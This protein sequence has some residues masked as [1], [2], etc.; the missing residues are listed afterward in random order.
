MKA[1]ALSALLALLISA[2]SMAASPAPAQPKQPAKPPSSL[3]GKYPLGNEKLKPLSVPTPRTTTGSRS[4]AP[5]RT[6]TQTSQTPPRSE[7]GGGGGASIPLWAVLLGALALSCVLG[8]AGES[9]VGRARRLVRPPKP[10]ELAQ[11][12]PTEPADEY[13]PPPEPEPLTVKPVRAQRDGSL[14]ASVEQLR[15]AAA[16]LGYDDPKLQAVVEAVTV[17]GE[18]RPLS[19]ATVLASWEEPTATVKRARSEVSRSQSEGGMTMGG[20]SA[21]LGNRVA[22]V[23]HA[24]EEVAARIREEAREEAAAIRRDAEDAATARV[25]H[26][27][28]EAEL[29]HAKAEEVLAEAEAQA[30]ARNEA[31]EETAARIEAEAIKHQEDLNA[32]ARALEERLQKTLAGLELVSTN[33]EQVLTS[34]DQAD[35]GNSAPQTLSA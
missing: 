25:A 24:A 35:D 18:W 26:L 29:L 6:P 28:Q 23:L 9:L 15:A 19:L 34:A 32:A 30:R 20:G 16:G 33:A 21:D 5:T 27:T 17:S 22:A 1:L 4:P 2:P 7:S 12:A 3:W 13:R 8:L 31:A 10:Y 11:Q 14:T